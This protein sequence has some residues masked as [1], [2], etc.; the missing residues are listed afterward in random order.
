[1]DFSM[2]IYVNTFLIVVF[3]WD[4]LEGL[5]IQFIKKG[6]NAKKLLEK[7]QLKMNH[8]FKCPY[9]NHFWIDFKFFIT[10]MLKELSSWVIYHMDFINS[11]ITVQS[12]HSSNDITMDFH[13]DTTKWTCMGHILFTKRNPNYLATI[14]LVLGLGFLV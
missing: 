10:C 13:F 3:V 11:L 12:P 5:N 6:N 14:H 9:H 1:M 4:I 7:L 8:I 2:C